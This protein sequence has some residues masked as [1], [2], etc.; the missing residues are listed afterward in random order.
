[1]ASSVTTA[2]SVLFGYGLEQLATP[3]ERADVLGRTMSFL[4]SPPAP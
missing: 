1:V 2:D 4:L 3:A